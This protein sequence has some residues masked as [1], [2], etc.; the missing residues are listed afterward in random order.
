MV[1][2]IAFCSIMNCQLQEQ[3]LVAKAVEM[4]LCTADLQQLENLVTMSKDVDLTKQ[5]FCPHQQL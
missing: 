4:C 2:D 5:D 3:G 1:Y